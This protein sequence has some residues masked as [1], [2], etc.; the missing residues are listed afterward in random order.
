M[1]PGAAHAEKVVT[2]DSSGDAEAFVFYQEFQFVPAPEEASV[3]ITRTV[4]ALGNRRLSVTVRF[5]DLEV[6]PRHGTEVRVRTPRAVFLV[7]AGRTSASR[8]KVTMAAQGRDPSR[9]RGLRVTYDGTADVVSVS[10]PT[11]CIGSPRWVRL[12]VGATA[13]PAANPQHPSSTVLLADDGHR[14]VWREHSLGTGP[15]IH[16]G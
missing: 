8:P 11:A 6:R 4:A 10:V 9:C 2:E 13:S 7:S 15:R 5:R 16:R 14:D 1:L 12:G 3:D